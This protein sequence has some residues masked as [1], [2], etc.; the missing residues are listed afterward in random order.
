MWLIDRNRTDTFFFERGYNRQ[1][2]A[3]GRAAEQMQS[4]AGFINPDIGAN[5]EL[6]E[7]Y[8]QPT[9]V[10]AEEV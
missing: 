10:N 8:D 4:T 5:L 1:E 6:S 9:T 7:V 2:L 3:F